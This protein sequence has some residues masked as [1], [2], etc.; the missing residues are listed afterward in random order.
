MASHNMRDV[1]IRRFLD[2]L[3]SQEPVPGGGAVAALAGAAVAALLQMVIALALRRAKDPGA[4]PALAFLLERAQVLQARFEELADADVAAYQRVADALALPRSTDTERAR[5]STVLQEALV[6]AAEVPLDT[7]RLAGEA[8]RLASEVAPLCPRAARS[9]LVTAIH[10]ARA[11]SAAALANVDAN[12]LS[13]DESSFR[14]ELARAR[15]DLADRACI[16]TEELLAPLEG[17]LRSW[18]GPR[19][20]SRA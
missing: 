8:L 4:A 7:A 14:W 15:E 2:E 16:L 13:L 20:A 5:R 12:A 6:G 9:D 17:G 19:G 10:L 11:T 18:L 3:A 1:T